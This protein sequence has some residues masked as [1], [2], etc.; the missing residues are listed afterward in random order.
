MLAIAG[1]GGLLAACSGGGAPP[2]AFGVFDTRGLDTDAAEVSQPKSALPPAMLRNEPVTWNDLHPLLVEMAGPAA[3]NEVVL[4]RELN[5]EFAARGLVLS[6]EAVRQEEDILL[7]TMA[8]EARTTP[9]EAARLLESMRASRG[10]GPVRFA[11]MLRRNAMLRALATEGVTVDD[12]DVKTAYAVRYGPK[13]RVRVIVVP[14]QRQA[15]ELRSKLQPGTP[16]APRPHLALEFA[17]AAA[18]FSTDP[19][20]ARGGSLPPMSL[21]DP[22]YPAAARDALRPLQPG[23]V[24]RPFAAPGG[25]AFFLLEERV[26]EA[27]PP[28]EEEV[29]GELRLEVTRVR[30]RLAMDDLARRMLDAAPLRVHDRGLEGARGK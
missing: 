18:K 30:E 1:V 22:T 15:G 5:R 19:S 13:V 23:Q 16:E 2:D 20:A 12:A 28:P 4:E 14:T 3:L 27:S 9:D 8:R 29:A 7:Q 6:D 21:E 24:T 25:F 10:L 17:D 26:D 11:A